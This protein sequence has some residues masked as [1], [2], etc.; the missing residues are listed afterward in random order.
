MEEVPG[1]ER[2]GREKERRQ[3]QARGRG[4]ESGRGGVL[5]QS[6]W[7]GSVCIGGRV[8]YGMRNGV[9]C[10]MPCRDHAGAAP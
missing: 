10:G 2:R 5:W 3:E 8:D 9:V 4:R 1:K 6:A 7:G